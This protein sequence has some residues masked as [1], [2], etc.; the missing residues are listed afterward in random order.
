MADKIREAMILAY[1]N[2]TRAVLGLLSQLDRHGA[3]D[4]MTATDDGI[5]LLSRALSDIADTYAHNL[6]QLMLC[7][8]DLGKAR[9]QSYDLPSV[10]AV[11]QLLE[12]KGVRAYA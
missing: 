12:L 8:S 7:G 6:N 10:R 4:A 9:I 11:E 5:Y 2:R 3:R 1:Q